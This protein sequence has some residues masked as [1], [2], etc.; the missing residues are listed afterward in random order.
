MDSE[1]KGCCLFYVIG[2]IAILLFALVYESNGNI[3]DG[4]AI[5]TMIAM[6][7][8]GIVALA[9]IAGSKSGSKSG[10]Y[11]GPKSGSYSS[12]YSSPSSSR[13]RKNIN[14]PPPPY[15]AGEATSGSDAYVEGYY[16]GFQDGK[17]AA[18][19]YKDKNSFF[20][21]KGFYYGYYEEKYEDGYF[22]GF[23]YAYKAFKG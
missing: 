21:C 17:K 1:N 13:P 3:S 9:V 15:M 12:P 11:S 5:V 20:K 16:F 6:A 8:A 7:G 14:Y 23:E 18:E 10:S 2:G 4:V 19:S 22:D